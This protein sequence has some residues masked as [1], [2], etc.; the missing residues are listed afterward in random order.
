MPREKVTLLALALA[1]GIALGW[2]QGGPVV[3]PWLAGAAVALGA[4]ALLHRRDRRGALA[5]MAAATVLF[6]AAWVTVRQDYVAPDDVA[7][8][9]ANAPLLMRVRGVALGPPLLRDRTT[10]SMGLFDHRP[11]ATYFP[12]EVRALVSRDGDETRV[13]GRLLVRVEQTLAPFRAG[14]RVETIG[15]LYPPSPPDNPGAF[16]YQ[17]YARSLGRAGMLHVGRRELV[18]VVRAPR[19]GVRGAWLRRREALRRCAGGWLL[20]D[21]PDLD[22]DRSQR[23]ALLGA[24]LLGRR[25]P[26]LDGLGES[27]RRAGLAHFLAISGLHLGVM[28]GFVLLLVRVGG[29]QQRW[30]G[31]I[32]IAAV[33]IY[34]VLVEVRM[35]VLR[36]GVMTIAACLGL[37]A[38][39]RMQVG[40]LVAASAVGLLLW[41]PDQLLGA[42]FQL[43]YGVVLGLIHLA[44]LM[45][46]R[47][48]GRPDAFASSS[49][50]MLGQWLRTTCAVAVTAWLV[51]M[52]IAL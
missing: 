37:V 47:W 3:W 18:T 44:P 21:L 20:A 42:G 14:D 49:A 33:L 34:L 10:G 23:D 22:T 19:A 26:E 25:G 16:N 11:P 40:G 46:T 2:G 15:L 39:R 45:R 50:Q 28:A 51:A 48:F 13:R 35:P 31:W 12:L 7:A 6:G 4:A 29:R 9:V 8:G 43:S 41:R 24:L 36:A 1:A 38:G 52:P 32:V 5:F 27:F 17:R 30:H